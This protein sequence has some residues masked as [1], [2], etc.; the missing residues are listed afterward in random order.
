ML[1]DWGEGER[2]S[3]LSSVI[4]Q[5]LTDKMTFEQTLERIRECAMQ[6]SRGSL[7]LTENTA[8][9]KAL[10]QEC[11]WSEILCLKNKT[12]TITLESVILWDF[13]CHHKDFGFHSKLGQQRGFNAYKL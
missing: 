10:S 12:E 11:S 13:K 5:G 9:T 4:W 3:F 2:F 8:S 1:W 6:I 7:F